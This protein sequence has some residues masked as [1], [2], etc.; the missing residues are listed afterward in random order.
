MWWVTGNQAFTAGPEARC[1]GVPWPLH[2]LSMM[3][4]APLEKML[5]GGAAAAGGTYNVDPAFAEE[6]NPAD[7]FDGLPWR[8]PEV[9]MQYHMARGL[10]V[11]PSSSHDPEVLMSD[12]AL[13]NLTK[14]NYAACWGGDTFGNVAVYDGSAP[15]SGVFGF[16]KVKKWPV[17]GRFGTGR[18]TKI[19]GLPDGTSNTLLLS[20]VV[21][22][23][24]TTNTTASSTHPSGSNRDGR[25]VMLLAGPGGNLFLTHTTPNSST[26]DTM[27]YCETNIPAGHPLRCVQNRTDGN[28]WAAAR[29]QHSGGVNAALADGSVRFF[30]DSI[31]PIVWRG[32][33]TKAGGEPV[34]VD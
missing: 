12:F 14:G 6:S 15:G 31:D 11:C 25:G 28:Q 9:M 17:E 27:M 29:S 24:E 21:A 23:G 7:N 18:G 20:E 5:S 33:G 22:Y 2:I 10:M 30:R 3:E 16:V 4:Q 1:Y 32:L 19:A 13:E 8:R 34:S 26:P